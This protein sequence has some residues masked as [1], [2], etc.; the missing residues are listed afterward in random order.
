MEQ[1]EGEMI[2]WTKP[3]RWMDKD[4]TPG[5]VLMAFP[6]GEAWVTST[7]ERFAYKF[8]ANGFCYGVTPIENIP[9]PV[10]PRVTWVWQFGDGSAEV[11]R[12]ESKARGYIVIDGFR[13]ALLK[14]TYTPGHASVEIIEERK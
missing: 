9:E 8:D 10:E 2:D 7:D 1:A 11:F 14:L 12:S 13:A 5:K 4:N 3:V 6:N